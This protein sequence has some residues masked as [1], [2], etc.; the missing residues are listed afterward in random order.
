MRDMRELTF[1]QPAG[2]IF[3]VAYTVSDI[4]RAAELFT[5]RLGVGPWYSIDYHSGSSALYRGRPTRLHLSILRGFVGHLNV[6]LVCQL[7]DTPS[8]F[9]DTIDK[10]G[11]GFHHWN[12]ASLDFDRD[13]KHYE[14]L[15]YEYAYYDT[16]NGHRLAFM[17]ATRDLPGMIEICEMTS[18]QEQ[19]LERMRLASV[20]FDGTNPIRDQNALVAGGR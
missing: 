15:G 2:G 7:D 17:D 20:N 14:Q 16:I 5:Q 12:I 18:D 11:Y 1:G 13:V 9:R 8:V 19:L 4:T 6:E 3:Q 10:S